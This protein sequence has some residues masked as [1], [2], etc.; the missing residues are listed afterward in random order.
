MAKG[1]NTKNIKSARSPTYKI[2]VSKPALSSSLWSAQLLGYP[3][4]CQSC[5]YLNS[6][7]P[8]QLTILVWN[9]HFPD[10][11]SQVLV[12]LSWAFIF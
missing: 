12:P 6:K 3:T 1:I 2:Q 7:G 11:Y 8:T 5:F 4:S 10:L 9:S